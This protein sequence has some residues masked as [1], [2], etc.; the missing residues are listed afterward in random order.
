MTKKRL[1]NLMLLASIAIISSLF[2]VGCGG[3]KSEKAYLTF[4]VNFQP[5]EAITDLL[6]EVVNDFNAEN[7][8]I[9]VEFIPGNSG[10]E[11]MMKAKMAANDLPDLWSTHGWSV[12]RYSEYLMPL[13]GE[14]WASVLHPAIKPVITDK[15]GH[16]YVLP[17]DVDVAGIAYNKDV[18]AKAGVNVDDIKTWDDLFVAMG[19]VKAMGITPVHIGGKD[20][21]TVGNFFDWAAPAFYVTDEANYRG[22][23][24]KA[25]H[26]DTATWTTL[27]AMFK[28]MQDNGYLN[29]DVLTSGFDETSKAL[30]S[31]QSAFEF[32]GNYVNSNAW[33]INPDANLG[34]FPVP[35]Y[36]KGDEPS[37]ISGERSTVGIWKDTEHPEE[38]KKF[39]EY[40][41]KPEVMSKLASANGIPAG[42]TTAKSDMGKLTADY[43]K[44]ANVPAYPYFDREFL[45]SGMWDTMCSTG[46]GVLSG[47]IAPEDA[48]YKMSTDFSKLYK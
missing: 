7:K 12:G 5:S 46:T 37:L 34:F 48:A 3:K 47:D 33:S 22:D 9:E 20:T 21:W 17:I 38:A 31:G 26:F 45:P 44:W 35:A 27:A 2:M 8:D 40:L 29:V 25:G 4:M 19:K 10:Y 18:V 41:A 42:L 30:A 39:L 24:L 28:G 11:A 16:I 32:F 14:E 43:E 36:F 15:A 23:D 6:E 1:L 13:E